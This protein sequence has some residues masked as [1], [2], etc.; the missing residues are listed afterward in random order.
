MFAEKR[1]ASDRIDDLEEVFEI[2]VTTFGRKGGAVP[3][4]GDLCWRPATDAYDT[5]DSFVVVMDLAGM[6]PGQIEILTD[7][8]SLT[9][10]GVRNEQAP[11]QKKHF[12]KMEIDVGPFVRRVPLSE[13]IDPA[14][15][16]ASYRNGFLTVTFSKGGRPN[17]KK[18][19]IEVE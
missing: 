18:R 17:G 4:E 2:L 3:S 19:K 5:E 15:G 1:I 10:R 7:G 16:V 14:S 8:Q 9:V 12:I 11:G 6:A 13:G